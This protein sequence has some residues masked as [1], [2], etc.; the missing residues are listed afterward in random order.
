MV[1]SLDRLDRSI[2]AEVKRLV[3]V[4]GRA[5]SSVLSGISK[6]RVVDDSTLQPSPRHGHGSEQAT[7]KQG[8]VS[9]R[10]LPI[11]QRLGLGVKTPNGHPHVLRSANGYGQ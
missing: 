8:F 9:R 1:G 6:W 2:G 5:N 10:A 3:W 7:S 4:H 11:P